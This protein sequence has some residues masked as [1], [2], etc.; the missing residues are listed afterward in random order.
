SPTML[1]QQVI[2]SVLGSELLL[3]REAREIDAPLVDEATES[4]DQSYISSSVCQH[5][6]LQHVLENGAR[7]RSAAPHELLNDSP[8]ALTRDVMLIAEVLNA[9]P[10]ARG[11]FGHVAVVDTE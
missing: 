2:P 8:I 9:A 11:A 7:F 1:A 10:E 5:S 4:V 6:R 3:A